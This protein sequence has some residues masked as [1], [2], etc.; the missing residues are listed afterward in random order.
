QRLKLASYLNAPKTKKALF[1]MDEPTF[2]LHM[3]D[4]LRLV[5]CF[6]ALI[7]AGHSFVVIEHNLHLIKHADWLIELGPG[8]AD[9]GGRI[10]GEGTPETFVDCLETPT[11]ICL[12]QLLLRERAV[13]QES[14][15]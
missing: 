8:A 3:K 12:K 2:G 6:N 4:I 13:L 7:A 14:D 5:D 10:I 11:S 15:G 9:Q 1:L